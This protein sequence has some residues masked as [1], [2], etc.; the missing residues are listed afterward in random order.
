MISRF[1]GWL[2]CSTLCC[3]VLFLAF[4]TSLPPSK[5]VVKGK[6]SPQ[7]AGRLDREELSAI[8]VTETEPSGG[9]LIP[10]K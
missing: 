8:K 3:L 9:R 4:G 6:N 5:M 7:V 10:Q 1:L 2:G